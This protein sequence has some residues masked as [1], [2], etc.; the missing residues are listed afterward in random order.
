MFIYIVVYQL[1]S[2]SCAFQFNPYSS[3]QK[4]NSAVGSLSLSLSLSLSTQYVD[5]GRILALDVISLCPRYYCVC[6]PCLL[7]WVSAADA[8]PALINVD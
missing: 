3:L 1:I 5:L 6:V 8:M 2:Y 7:P 4:F